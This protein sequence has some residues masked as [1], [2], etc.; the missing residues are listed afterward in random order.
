MGF[1]INGTPKADSIIVASPAL[2]NVM[3]DKGIQVKVE[4][5][6]AVPQEP[7]N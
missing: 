1:K 2:D 7:K 5:P 6:Q 3:P 4:A